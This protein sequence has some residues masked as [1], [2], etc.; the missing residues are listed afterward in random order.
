MKEWA[1][2]HPWMTFFL[3][4]SAIGGTVKIIVSVLRCFNKVPG[5][6]PVEELGNAIIDE[7]KQE[8]KA[9]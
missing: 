5:I 9:E 4:D 1:L 8:E 2:K 6:T 3:V 7:F